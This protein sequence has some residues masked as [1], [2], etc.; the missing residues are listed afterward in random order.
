MSLFQDL[1]IL[2]NPGASAATAT[3]ATTRLFF[4]DYADYGCGNYC[5]NHNQNYKC[6]HT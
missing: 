6:S 4:L 3:A 5:H 2:A 1:P